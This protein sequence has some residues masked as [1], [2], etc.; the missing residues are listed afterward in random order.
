[1]Y[2]AL[3][4]S[5]YLDAPNLLINA[6]NIFLILLLFKELEKNSDLSS[7]QLRLIAIY[8][9]TGRYDG[10]LWAKKDFLRFE[11]L[12]QALLEDQESFQ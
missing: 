11:K 8:R 5:F 9:S 7:D 2:N 3:G 4:V 10:V 12:S 1:M 6:T